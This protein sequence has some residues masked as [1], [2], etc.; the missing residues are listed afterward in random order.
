MS[1]LILPGFLGI[2]AQKAGTTW[3]HENLSC[4]P[5]L[6]LPPEKELHYFD[7]HVDKPLSWYS[8]FFSAA[9]NRIP[10]DITPAYSFLDQ[11]R[12]RH[13]HSLIPQAR[14]I[15][16]L[17]DPIERAW[18]QAL[19]ILVRRKE[20]VFNDIPL[21]RLRKVIAKPRSLRR[22]DYPSIIRNWSTVFPNDQLFIGFFEQIADDPKTLLGKVLTHIGCSAELDWSCTPY[23]KVVFGGP[24]QEMPDEVYQDLRKFYHDD[25]VWLGDRFGEPAMRWCRRYDI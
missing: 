20:L 17:R 13:I 22:G 5:D 18:S 2:G 11:A 16:I 3:L 12:I 9:G 21:A 6:F 1:Q 25:L 24:K 23:D 19:M 8:K 10:G 15:L 14:L 4:H 7:R